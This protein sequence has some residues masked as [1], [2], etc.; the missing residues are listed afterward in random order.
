MV[1]VAEVV[2][3]HPILKDVVTVNLKDK[4]KYKI[5]SN[6]DHGK[7]DQPKA[8]IPIQKGLAWLASDV[9]SVHNNYNDGADYREYSGDA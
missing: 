1:H 3:G 4:A 5:A 9:M 2:N 8:S 6:T 7:L